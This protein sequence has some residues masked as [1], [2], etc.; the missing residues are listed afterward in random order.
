MTY[1]KNIGISFA[2]I[3]GSILGLT[4]LITFLHYFNIIGSKILA[5]LEIMIPLLAMFLGGL[6]IG[7]RSKKHG[8][9]EGVKLAFFFIILLVLFQYLGLQMHFSVKILLFYILLF[10]SSIAGSMVGINRKMPEEKNQPK[11]V[12]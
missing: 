9:M 7:K 6:Q 3:I 1:L 4:L 12:I 2:F 5:I 11:K 10:I 8:W